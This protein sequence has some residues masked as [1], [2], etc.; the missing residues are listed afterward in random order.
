MLSSSGHLNITISPYFGSENLYV[1]LEPNILEPVAMVFSI[2]PEGTSELA[3]I[4]VL[5]TNAISIA[6]A[7]TSSQLI[8]S[9]KNVCF[10]EKSSPKILPISLVRSSYAFSL[11]SFSAPVSSCT[12]S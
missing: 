12:F 1:S 10:F 5:R 9:L 2:E 7:I 6:A 8:A 11:G 4:N 3:I